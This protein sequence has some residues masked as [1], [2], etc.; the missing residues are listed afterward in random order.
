MLVRGS[1]IASPKERRG[2]RPPPPIPM[3]IYLRHAQHGTK[4][5]VSEMEADQDREAGWERYDPTVPSAP[6][7]NALRRPRNNDNRNRAN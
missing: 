3:V 4:V 6:V 1:C 5:A 2:L 7:V